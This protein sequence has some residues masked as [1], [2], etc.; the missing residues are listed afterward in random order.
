MIRLLRLVTFTLALGAFLPTGE[1]APRGESVPDC[2]NSLTENRARWPA[3]LPEPFE[4]ARRVYVLGVCY[5][6][7]DDPRRA[8]R[9]FREGARQTALL[10]AEWRF[11]LFRAALRQERHQEALAGLK[12]VLRLSPAPEQAEAIRDFLSAG[13][14]NEKEGQAAERHLQF[15]SAYVAGVTP[16]RQDH[17]LIERLLNL[18]RRL[19]AEEVAARLPLLLWR[20]PKDEA[21]AL[22][23]REALVEATPA[24][25]DY[26]VRVANLFALRLFT[27][28][29]EELEAPGLPPL[30]PLHAKT[31]GRYYLRAL[32]RTKAYTRAAELIN[33]GAIKERFSLDTGEILS[34]AVDI[35]LRK[36]NV[37][38][39]ERLIA[40]AER[41]EP[42]PTRL[43][44]IYLAMARYYEARRN[45]AGVVAW[46]TRVIERF[47]AHRLTGTAYW[48]PFWIHYR[49][50]D[51]EQARKWLDRAIADAGALDSG[52]RAQFLY[53]KGRLQE[54]RGQSEEAAGTWAQLQQLWPTSF[55]ALASRFALHK[56]ELKPR[57]AGSVP[58]LKERGEP[59]RLQ[60]VW[61]NDALARA[62]F[63]FV[64]GEETWAAAITGRIM[65]Q[66]LPP[67]II[68]ELGEVFRYFGRYRL[69]NRLAA[70]YHL[71]KLRRE[72]PSDAAMWQHA[73]PRAFWDV[74]LSET[75]THRVNPFFVLAVMREESHFFAEA[76]STAG[77]KG[78][79]QLMPATARMVARRNRLEYDDAA[80]VE[81]SVNIPLGVL[82]LK[83]VLN[84]FDWN[85]VHAAAAYNAGPTAVKRWRTQFGNLPPAEFVERIPYDET[86]AYVKRVIASY[87]IYRQLYDSLSPSG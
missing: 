84:R 52:S 34:L 81:P 18:A 21:S 26:L 23:W 8:A 20:L 22:R 5:L 56:A 3:D 44:E 25:E 73:Y 79:M 75:G 77:A 12:T 35:H 10:G 49:R 51:F 82:Y 19:G 69:Q 68:R 7:N 33:S 66:P 72:A 48:L 9:F 29:I 13:S 17:D 16:T 76:N 67:E 6:E 47:P 27:P 65:G 58:P 39:A 43:A 71:K 2:S 59:P 74:V 30:D 57:F 24:G 14:E 70:N 31:L 46:S 40:K 55:Y 4:A 11:N 64:V 87:L 42:P 80:L 37:A 41:T 50:R 45:P 38:E 1:A 15:L 85:P 60:A 53:W 54:L 28:L 62:L 36:R 86:R 61:E 32:I 83:R 63:L 78:L